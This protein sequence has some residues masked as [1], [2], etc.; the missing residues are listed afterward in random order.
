MSK[1]LLSSGV[2][3]LLCGV[4]SSCGSGSRAPGVLPVPSSGSTVAAAPA[5]TSSTSS[6]TTTT[7]SIST[8]AALS[9]EPTVK[10]PSGPA[11]KQLV[12]KDL[13]KG[14][15]ATAT[16][17]STIT[18]NY[19]GVLYKGGKQFDASWKRHQTFTTAL[20]AGPGG[21][22]DGWVKGLAGMRVG[23]RR[24]LI[25]PPGLAYKNQAQP[26]IPAGS[27]LIFVIDLLKVG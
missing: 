25:I 21:V 18:V 14:T 9:T 8:P 7:A 19:V 5:T 16:Q 1:R 26:G 10:P 12:I 3:V 20:T 23:G 27:P 13:I 15:G 11:P 6:T 22:I 2:I 24:E 17:G 4:L